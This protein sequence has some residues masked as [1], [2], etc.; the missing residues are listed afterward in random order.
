M[1]LTITIPEIVAKHLGDDPRRAL[2]EPVLEEM[3]LA[4]TITIAR[5]GEILGLDRWE[6]AEWWTSL[7]HGYPNFTHEQLKD[8]LDT[9]TDLIPPKD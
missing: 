7:G 6:S 1:D 5:A 4:Q 3:V 2:L 9:L 8:H